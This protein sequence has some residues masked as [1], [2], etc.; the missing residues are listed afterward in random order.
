[1]S[2][3]PEMLKNPKSRTKVKMNMKMKLMQVCYQASDSPFFFSFD[4]F[5]SFL[6]SL[7]CRNDIFIVMVVECSCVC[8]EC[9]EIESRV[10]VIEFKRD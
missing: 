9:C 5:S 4:S 2:H 8:R 6:S 7:A 3:Q 10:R 1:M